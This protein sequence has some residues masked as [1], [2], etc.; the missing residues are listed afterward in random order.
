ML[1]DG[2]VRSIYA[3]KEIRAG[4][5]MDVEIYPEFSRKERDQIPD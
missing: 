1:K 3:T 2:K 5:Q 4:D